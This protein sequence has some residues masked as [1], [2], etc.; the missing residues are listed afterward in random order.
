[1]KLKVYEYPKCSTCRKALAF[2][3][4]AGM[5]YERVD[6]VKTPPSKSELKQ[7]L[8]MQKGE[9]RKLF[10]TSGELYREFKMSERL[11]QMSDAE[12]LDLLSQHGKLIKRP[13]LLT[14]SAGLL[15]FNSEQWTAAL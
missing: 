14:D 3:D 8:A 11:S 9:I 10:N 6:I 5:N 12:E 13:F 4:Q 2:L 15:G 7:M 1:M